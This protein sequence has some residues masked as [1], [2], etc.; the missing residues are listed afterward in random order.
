MSHVGV[1]KLYAYPRHFPL[2]TL[3]VKML[4]SDKPKPPD[5]DYSLLEG[6]TIYIIQWEMNIS[7]LQLSCPSIQDCNG[8]MVA[9]RYDFT[10][11]GS[12]TPIQ[13]LS[14]FT[15]FA[16]SMWFQYNCCKKQLSGTN[17]QLFHQVPFQ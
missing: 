1:K 9:D 14:C 3:G 5:Y 15:D 10:R 16:V 12:V 4:L 6:C 8:T 2:G 7:N 11:W 13:G 17:R